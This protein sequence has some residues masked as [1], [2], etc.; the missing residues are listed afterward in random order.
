MTLSEVVVTEM[1]GMV[2]DRTVALVA[3]GVVIICVALNGE[4]VE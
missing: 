2:K 3:A 4:G 1:L